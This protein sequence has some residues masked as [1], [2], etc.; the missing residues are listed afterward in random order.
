MIQ[1]CIR[2]IMQGMTSSGRVIVVA[3]T[4][5][6][7]KSQLSIHLAKKFNGEVINSDSMQMYKGIPIITNKHPL[8]EREGIEHHVMNH[9]DWTEE[10]YIHRFEKECIKTIEDIHRRGKVA[11]V[12]GGTHYYLQALFN[13]SVN[14]K[15]REV[16]EEES[17]ILNS[18]DGELTYQTLIKH[19]PDIASK[20]HPNDT[21]RVQRMLEIYY[22]TGKKPSEMFNEQQNSLRYN[23]LFF[24]LYSEPDALNKRL[25]DRVD[26]MLE[27]GGMEEINELYNYYKDNNFTAEQCEN[28]VWQVIGFKEFLPWLE[29]EPN[30]SL[31]DCVERMKIRTRQYAKSQVKWIKKMLIPDING[32]IYILDATDLEKWDQTVAVRADN[33]ATKFIEDKNIDELKVPNKLKSLE[34]D[35]NNLDKTKNDDFE[36]FTCDICCD[37][38]NNKLLAIG[39]K[40]WTIH[41]SSRRHRANLKRS[42]KKEDYLMYKQRKIEPSKD[43]ESE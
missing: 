25:D 37:K 26:K 5:G 41:L 2:G 22:T 10:Y 12:V 27:T 30:V 20:Y 39:N 34:F 32:D 13:K 17:E 40:N 23:T 36:H 7:G 38:N 4:T 33:I 8:A 21:R 42:Q 16:T 29:K 18:G 19:D 43:Q 3:G 28:G 11:I 31:P 9:V 15:T 35:K 24:W 14:E 1:M 6:V